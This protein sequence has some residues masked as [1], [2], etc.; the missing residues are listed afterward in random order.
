IFPNV[1]IPLGAFG[2][3]INVFWPIDEGSTRLDWIYYGLPEDGDSFDAEQLP[4]HW[5]APRR[6]Y[7][8]TQAE[9]AM[10][11]API[12]RSMESPAFTGIPI[13]Y[14]ERR[15][16][17]LHEQIDRVIG[18]DNVPASMR[19]PPLLEPYV[20]GRAASR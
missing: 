1:I 3:P 19:V 13:N 7:N 4:D 2:F 14:Q 18:V 5:Q 8:Q 6:S 11:M 10:N 9:D 17:H 15:I 20:L 12:Q 16:W